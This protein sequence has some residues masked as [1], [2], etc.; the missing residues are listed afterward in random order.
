MTDYIKKNT[1]DPI[2]DGISDVQ[3][4][5]S[6]YSES[7][8][9]ELSNFGPRICAVVWQIAGGDPPPPTPIGVQDPE[10]PH[11]GAG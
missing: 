11:R 8:S 4:K 3:I 10:I 7:L 9:L 1:F 6:A 5:K 2:R